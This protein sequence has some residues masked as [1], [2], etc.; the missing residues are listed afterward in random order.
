MS[1]KYEVESKE[2]TNNP[3][4]DGFKELKKEKRNPISVRQYIKKQFS[5]FII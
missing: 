2:M 5:Y 4:T 3:L 1:S